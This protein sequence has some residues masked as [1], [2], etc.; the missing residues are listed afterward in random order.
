MLAWLRLAMS[1]VPTATG[2]LEITPFGH[3]LVYALDHLLTGTLVLEEQDGSKHAV[4]FSDG[5][6]AKV[7]TAR[8]VVY[9]GQILV[10]R[11]LVS[12]DVCDRTRE[13]AAAQRRL[14]GEVLRA[15]GAID[16]QSL[17]VALREQLVRKVLWLFRLP[18][19]TVYGYYDRIDFLERWG[20]SE[21][22]RVKP[23]ELIWRGVREFAPP[24]EVEARVA[25]L[26]TTPIKLHI[27]APIKRFHFEPRE[28]AV[29]DVLR[30]KPQPLY[31]LLARG[32]GTEQEVK[33]LIYGLI[34]TRQLETGIPG[35][36][37]VGVD[38]APSSSRIPV[39]PYTAQAPAGPAI[40]SPPLAAGRPSE[41]MQAPQPAQPV[42]RQPA[43]QQAAQG[44]ENPEVREL[45]QELER[46]AEAQGL[47]HYEVL[48][49]EPNATT[50]VIQAAFFALA[51]K[52]HPDRLAPELASLRELATRVFARMT[53][54]N[55]VLTDPARRR[56]YDEQRKHQPSPD[57]VEQVQRV[58]RATTAYQKAEV[59]LKRNNL[60]GAEAEAK[61]AVDND[62]TQADHVA[63][64]AWIQSLK[65]NAP[66]EECLRALDRAVQ[67]EQNNLRVRWYRGQL[68]KRMSKENRA[69]QDF[70][71]IV[72]KDPRHLDAQREIRLYEMRRSNPSTGGDKRQADKRQSD[73][74]PKPAEGGLLGRLFKKS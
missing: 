16:A 24:A 54:A 70:R 18:P 1:H 64:Y 71:F 45:R 10:E 59:L 17:R 19:S 52:W 35:V 23:L 65:P 53:E 20:G 7:K 61:N 68:L 8:P 63:L 29:I 31:E 41:T 73:S 28:Q 14:H 49:V 25:R 67:M 9:L 56:E 69:I 48:G 62:P 39:A 66:L 55:Q 26:G 37:P 4:L 27:D 5:A 60:A 13:L 46:L 3:L 38:E 30:A 34:I 74:Q 51:K 36:E 6:P 42:A 15:E 11:G 33:R 50:E 32:L 21:G 44:A 22:V 72:E 57:E 43:P 12:A 2:S 40:F 47:S 58:L